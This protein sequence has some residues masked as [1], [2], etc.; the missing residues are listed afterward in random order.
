ME[1]VWYIHFM[2]MMLLSLYLLAPFCILPAQSLTGAWQNELGSILIIDSLSADDVIYG[3]Y[4][5][6]SG[7]DGRIFSLQGWANQKEPE[8]SMAISFTVHW[9]DYGSITSWTGFLDEDD[10]GPY[11]KTLWH[12]VRPNETE[13]WERIIT[14]SSTFRPLGDFKK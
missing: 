13:L 4:R 8:I 5:S 2:K 11:I 6:S 10:D 12:L 14:N 7:V 3:E 1:P 9:G